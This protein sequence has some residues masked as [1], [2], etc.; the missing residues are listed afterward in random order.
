MF[1]GTPDSC[2]Y[3]QMWMQQ[4]LEDNYCN[5]W[6]GVRYLRQTGLSHTQSRQKKTQYSH[7]IENKQCLY[8]AASYKSKQNVSPEIVRLCHSFVYQL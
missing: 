2:Q 8:V 3:C 5:S 6:I 1:R 4:Y 7:F